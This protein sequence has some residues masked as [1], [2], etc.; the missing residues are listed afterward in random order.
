MAEKI[1]LNDDVRMA[2]STEVPEGQQQRVKIDEKKMFFK[3]QKDTG[4]PVVNTVNIDPMKEGI[5]V[6]RFPSFKHM[7]EA[8]VDHDGSPTAYMPGDKGSDKLKNGYN[9]GGKAVGFDPKVLNAE[10]GYVSTTSWNRSKK[11]EDIPYQ[12][13]YVDSRRVPYVVVPK[14]YINQG[15]KMGDFVKLRNKVNGKETWA[16][17]ADTREILKHV[18]ISI[19]ACRQLGIEF[20]RAG[21]TKNYQ[22][23]AMEAFKGSASGRWY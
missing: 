16:V 2:L 4:F 10:G 5:D 6:T 22:R 23:V 19:A 18:E 3:Y 13:N 14:K 12:E 11:E 8:A 21:T 17:V 20:N 7:G 9:K 1:S 15:G